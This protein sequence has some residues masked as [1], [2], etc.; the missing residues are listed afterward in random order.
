MEHAHSRGQ[1]HQNA[2]EISS[3]RSEVWRLI[4]ATARPGSRCGRPSRHRDISSSRFQTCCCLKFSAR[5]CAALSFDA[6]VH[7]FYKNRLN[8]Y[9][10]HGGRLP[11][12]SPRAGVFLAEEQTAGRGRGANSWE[13]APLRRHLLLRGFCGPPL[14]PSDVLVISLAAGLAVHAAIEQV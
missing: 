14:P 9:G 10:G 3:N 2:Q 12:A 5:C 7:H 13:S 8:Q 4:Q 1:R 6:H 11:M